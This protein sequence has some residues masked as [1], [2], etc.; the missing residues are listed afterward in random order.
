MSGIAGFTFSSFQRKEEVE[1]TIRRMSVVL[2]QRGPDSEKSYINE[3][4][5]LLHRGLCIE[6]RK[7]KQ[8]FISEDKY[9]IMLWDGEIYNGNELR[10]ELEKKGHRFKGKTDSEIVLH[11]FR[12]WGLDSFAKL[13]GPFAIAI[14][15]KRRKI[16]ALARDHLGQKPF[17][18]TLLNGNIL[19]SSELRVLLCHPHI[20]KRL[21]LAVLSK[22]LAYEY[23]PTPN[24]IVKGAKKI[25]HGHCLLWERGK[26]SLRRFWNIRF[27][28]AIILKREE[29]YCEMVE[30]GIKET[31]KAHHRDEEGILLS[32]G[33]DS[34]SDVA[35]VSELYPEQKI[36]TFSLGF[37]EEAFDESPYARVVSSL[38]S[39]E[40]HNLVLNSEKMQEL[41]FEVS[42]IL[43][44]PLGDTS[45]FPTYLL[46][47]FAKEYVPAVFSGDS[48]DELFFGYP[49]FNAHRL[50]T[51]YQRLPL[52]LR[53]NIIE[54]LV[55]KMPVN[56]SSYYSLDFKAKQFLKGMAYPPGI[57]NQVWLGSFSPPEQR[58]LFSSRA[59]EYLKDK[60]PYEDIPE[61]LKDCDASNLLDRIDYLYLKFYLPDDGVVK[62]DRAATGAGLVVRSPFLDYK[63]WDLI[64]KIPNSLKLHRF[65]SKYILKRVMRKKLPKE[66]IY[67]KKR[68]FAIPRGDWIKN[69]LKSLFLETF[70]KE[71]IE[72][73]GLFNFS[74]INQ[75][76]REHLENK[77]DNNKQL[78]ILFMFE[79]WYQK[80]E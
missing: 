42:S 20:E 36:K 2:N 80:W 58:L 78:W 66:V 56:T 68:G 51:I 9:L 38:F 3:D 4:I 18:Y 55:Y 29:E 39:T 49:T 22:Y 74:Y 70:S 60:S 25:P 13:R 33:L 63:F 31:I 41:L 24:A 47:K 28:P 1:R 53:E 19:F 59:R 72:K 16:L 43:D 37:E 61:I 35:I 11:S 5:A 17:F 77:K 54:R 45:V 50:A 12:E 26:I 57:R 69:R 76:L 15:D 44:E 32:G 64:T 30:E 21:D 6:E 14:W 67:R 65:T 8:P 23:V 52:F 46:M 40:H 34:S 7:E 62:V 48:G 71:R 27:T 79:L 10:E 73:E 75:L